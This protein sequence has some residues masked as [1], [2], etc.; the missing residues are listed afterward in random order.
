MKRKF[1]RFNMGASAFCARDCAH[2]STNRKIAY[3]TT[4]MGT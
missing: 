3:G 4:G 2:Q 1:D